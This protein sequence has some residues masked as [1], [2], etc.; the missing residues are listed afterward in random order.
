MLRIR[1]EQMDALQKRVV[2]DKTLSFKRTF[3]AINDADIVFDA[4]KHLASEV[5]GFIQVCLTYARQFSI[6]SHAAIQTFIQLVYEIGVGFWLS[7]ENQYV[8]TILESRYMD[9]MR[10]ADIINELDRQLMDDLSRS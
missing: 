10:L 1:Q 2:D 3:L 6:T 5:D 8:L 7:T 4:S 9:E